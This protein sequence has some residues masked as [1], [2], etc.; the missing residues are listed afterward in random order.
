MMLPLADVG[1]CG[2]LSWYLVRR[3]LIRPLERLKAAVLAYQPATI[4]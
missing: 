2:V 3:L 4:V 1:G